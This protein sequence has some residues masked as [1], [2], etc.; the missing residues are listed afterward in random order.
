MDNFEM[1]RKTVQEEIDKHLR[2]I[3]SYLSDSSELLEI[4]RYPAGTPTIFDFRIFRAFSD[5]SF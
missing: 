5:C 1:D 4:Q 2:G 3:R